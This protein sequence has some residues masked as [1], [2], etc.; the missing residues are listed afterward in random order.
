MIIISG[1]KGLRNAMC[2]CAFQVWGDGG[3]SRPC[4]L[5]TPSFSSPGTMSWSSPLVLGTPACPRLFHTVAICAF[6]CIFA[7]KPGNLKASLVNEP[8]ALDPLSRRCIN[9]LFSLI[10]LLSPSFSHISS[11]PSIIFSPTPSLSSPLHVI[12]CNSSSLPC[13]YLLLLPCRLYILAGE[14]ESNT[15]DLC[16]LQLG[17]TTDLSVL[18]LGHESK[19]KIMASTALTILSS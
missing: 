7:H 16:V 13:L 12:H 8:T 9:S 14:T 10:S 15:A 19:S 3:T 6:A 11:S 1:N 18:Q 2:V 5:L 4:V 17:N